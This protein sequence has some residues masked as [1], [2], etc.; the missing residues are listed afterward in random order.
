[1]ASEHTARQRRGIVVALLLVASLVAFFAVFAVWAKRQALETDTW[2]KTSS[3]M[4]ENEDIRDAVAGFLVEQLFAAADVQQ[5]L[6][7][8]LPKDIKPLAG[9]ASGGLREF[10]DQEAPKLL[11]RPRVQALWEE[12]NRAAHKQL[13]AIVEGKSGT[14]SNQGGDVKLDLR[15]LVSQ[16]AAQTGLPNVA[17]K[18]PPD[19]AEIV[20]LHS[21]ELEAAQD[22]VNLLNTLAW[23]LT[24]IALVLYALAVY[25]AQGWRREALRSVGL[26]FIAV[27]IAALL[28][29][30]IAGG[31]VVSSLATTAT[32]EPAANAA[33]SIGTSVLAEIAGAMVLYGVFIILSAWLA[34]ETKAAVAV[35]REIAPYYH[36]PL[37]AYATL[38]VIVALLFWW[39]PTEGLTRPVPAL[40]LIGF[41]ILGT[42]TLRR[43]VT[44]EF[45]DAT[46]EVGAERWAERMSGLRDQA[47]W[48][49]GAV[50]QPEPD[51]PLTRLE[52]L[53][54]LKRDG[55]LTD[56]EF[57]A[58]KKAILGS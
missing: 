39:A 37:F 43:Q 52:R 12:A 35:R 7:K 50:K 26:S 11:E 20:I 14:V 9:P 24:L 58:Q 15:L 32:I 13:L 42:E 18:I 54:T 6:E 21:D 31:A 22:G 5:R 4:L 1:V 19:K 40:I 25:L 56:E 17:D 44:R 45:P 33:W 36:E 38:V 16:L 2:A 46:R 27:G 53:G 41:L 10:A 48:R 55:L 23:L 47:R 8:A 29:R 49:P 30:K 34:G 57:E 51:D 3:K 28:A